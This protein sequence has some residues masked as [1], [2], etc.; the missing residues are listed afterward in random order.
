MLRRSTFAGEPPFPFFGGLNGQSFRAKTV[1]NLLQRLPVDGF[2]ETGTFHGFTSALIAAQTNLPVYTVE[3]KRRYFLAAQPWRLRFPRR[4]HIVHGDSRSFLA[5]PAL[6]GLHLPLVYLDA[7]WFELPLVGELKAITDRFADAVIVIDDFKVP[8]DD[9]YGYDVY[10][11]LSLDMDLIRPALPE[12]TRAFFPSTP[13]EQETGVSYWN[14]QIM[15]KRGWVV[16]GW[17]PAVINALDAE[18]GLRPEP[19]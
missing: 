15:K 6:D 19:E 17:T 16:L 13:A 9:G 3:N 18:P 14:G 4:L 10:G 7:H 12:R 2:V 1:L 11:D 5:S 8:D